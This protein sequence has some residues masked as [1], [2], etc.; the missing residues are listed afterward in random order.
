MERTMR[1]EKVAG[2][3]RASEPHPLRVR[4]L[5]WLGL[6][7]VL[8]CGRPAVQPT[9]YVGDGVYEGS[10][11]MCLQTR[12]EVRPGPWQKALL[13]HFKNTCDYA[14]DCLVYND[15]T[16]Q[17]QRAIVFA[18]RDAMLIVTA[19]TDESSF[20]IELDCQWKP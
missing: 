15:V 9:A 13:V 4:R 3:P 7:L 17:E 20:D 10:P 8:S 5:V 2:A 18:D 16:E 19:A 1:A 12:K 6:V 14:I 11:P